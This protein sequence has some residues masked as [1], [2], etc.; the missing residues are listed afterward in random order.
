MKFSGCGPMSEGLP[1]L[2][3]ILALKWDVTVRAVSEQRPK[4]SQE[5]EVKQEV[6]LMKQLNAH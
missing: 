1:H 2:A 6:I 4:E 3:R 5:N